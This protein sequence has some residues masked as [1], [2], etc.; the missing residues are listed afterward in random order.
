MNSKISLEVKEVTPQESP[1][2][3]FSRSIHGSK[4][5]TTKLNSLTQLKRAFASKK[6][7]HGRVVKKIKGGVLVMLL[8]FYAFLPSSHFLIP[9]ASRLYR[10]LNIKKT[11]LLAT[12]IP[13]EI[14]G[15]KYLTLK[16]GYNKK[17]IFLLNIVVSFR[18]ALDTLNK[19][20]KTL[21]TKKLIRITKLKNCKKLKYDQ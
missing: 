16:P 7:V 17:K 15:I 9:N 6:L 1:I 5:F 18:K 2:L 8:G 10:N 21:I 19:H 13:L 3:K 14:L 11:K 4:N 20:R 12:A